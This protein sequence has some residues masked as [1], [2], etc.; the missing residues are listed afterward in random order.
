VGQGQR[1]SRETLRQ[2]MSAA[3]LWK[4]GQAAFCV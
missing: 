4:P 3:G 2:W 1:V